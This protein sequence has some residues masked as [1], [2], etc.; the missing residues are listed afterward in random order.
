MEKEHIR[1]EEEDNNMSYP[2]SKYND[3]LDA[4]TY[5]QAF[6]TTWEANHV[7]QR[8]DMLKI[9]EFG[10]SLSDKRLIDN[11]K[12]S[13]ETLAP[14]NNCM[15]NCPVV[16][17]TSCVEGI[18]QPILRGLPRANE[19]VLSFIIR[20]QN[21]QKQLTQQPLE[22]ELKDAFPTA[23]GEPFWITL[24]VLEFNTKH[25]EQ[26]IDLDRAENNHAMSMG[27]LQKRIFKEEELR[28]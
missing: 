25:L 12:T 9:V 11:P 2:Y 18:D 28:L 7:F 8:P 24:A 5:I 27:A 26:V 1:V 14:S 3:E 10:L 21:L 17:P 16:P 13:K 22:E 15:T 19:M 23:L 6:L 4:K 20:F